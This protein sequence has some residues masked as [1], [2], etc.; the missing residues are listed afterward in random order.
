MEHLSKIHWYLSHYRNLYFT[1]TLLKGTLNFLILFF[2]VGI[3]LLLTDL[4]IHF[5]QSFLSFVRVLFG[6]YTLLMFV[7]YVVRPFIFWVFNLGGYNKTWIAKKIGESDPEID[8][9]LINILELQNLD[10]NNNLV[11]A[12]L[13]QKITGINLDKFVN[14]FSFNTL[15]RHFIGFLF[16]IF[17]TGLFYFL[18]PNEVLYSTSRILPI[19][20]A[21]SELPYKIEISNKKLAVDKGSDYVLKVL[22]KG[23]IIPEKL[24]IR[25][26]GSDKLLRD[27]SNVFTYKFRSVQENLNFKIYND[28]F[29]SDIYTLNCLPVPIIQKIRITVNPPTYTRLQKTE[30]QGTGN[31]TFPYGSTV[32]WNI[33]TYDTDSL[34]FVYGEKRFMAKDEDRFHINMLLTSSKEYLLIPVNKQQSKIDSLRFKTRL[35]PDQYPGINLNKYKASLFGDF[36]FGGTIQDDYGFKDLKYV[37]KTN[38]TTFKSEI[39][40]LTNSLNQEFRYGGKLQDYSFIQAKDEVEIYLELRDNDPFAPY[41]MVKTKSLFTKLPDSEEMQAAEQKNMNQLKDKLKLGKNILDKV[42]ED[43]KNLRKNLLEKNL[44]KW[45]RQQLAKQIET[46]SKEITELQKQVN[47]LREDLEKIQKHSVNKKLLDKKEQLEKM[48]DK[49]MDKE[50]EKLLNDLK[51]LQEDLLQDK[52]LKPQKNDFSF[53]DLEKELDRNIEMLKRYEVERDQE[54]VIDE[55]KE[56][57]KKYKNVDSLLQ[58]PGEQ[59]DSLNKELENTLD[60]HKENLKKNQELETPLELDDFSQ[61][62]E[63]IKNKTDQLKQD[64]DLQQNENNPSEDIEQLADQMQMNMQMAMQKQKGEDAEMIRE[65]LENLLQ[66]SYKQEELIDKFNNRQV[67]NFNEIRRQQAGLKP[68][69]A[70]VEDSLHALMNRNAMVASAIGNQLQTIKSHFSSIQDIFQEERFSNIEIHQQ[71]IMQSTNEL[72]LML[73]ESL[74]NMQ[75]SMSGKGGQNKSGKKSKPGMGGMKKQQQSFKES[76]QKMIDELKKGSK[77][78][79]G[80]KGMSKQLS[81]MLS[82]QEKMQQL[83]QQIMQSGGVGQQSRQILKEINKMVDQNIDDI[84]QRNISDNMLQRQQ[85]I[86]NRMLEAEKA[87]QEREKEKKRE[88]QAP[89]NYEISNPEEKYEYKEDSKSRK[90][91]IYRKELPLKYFFQRK[92]DKYLNEIEKY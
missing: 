28:E 74:D 84:I 55:L 56:L 43:Q 37:I 62:K 2:S 7:Y 51:K 63:N 6:L 53:N 4:A 23:S 1:R 75:N 15:L 81:E 71:K 83:L 54:Q 13:N 31:F 25:Y 30:I 67:H 20:N 61:E 76:I 82:Q 9:K 18:S 52:E 16:V 5:S 19:T 46:T 77:S 69:F 12:S 27:S 45:E 79:K 65:L 33:D 88:S 35:I 34:I 10:R 92:Y 38:D 26:G 86:L 59:V 11:D 42:N 44:S 48:L 68:R 50:L 87:E 78:G 22:V 66:F 90:G 89:N 60:K 70:I 40:L 36:M 47:Q 24:K 8:D 21:N 49:L 3:L 72:I 57:S 29:Q 14:F 58:K 41:K 39:P 91:I 64:Q 80:K 85:K 17:L 73:N 32:I